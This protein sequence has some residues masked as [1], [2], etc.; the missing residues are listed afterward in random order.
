MDSPPKKEM[1]RDNEKST[2]TTTTT[3]PHEIWLYIHDH[4]DIPTKRKLEEALGWPVTGIHT[5]PPA[6]VDFITHRMQYYNIGRGSLDHDYV[7]LPIPP[8][9]KDLKKYYSIN[10]YRSYYPYVRV[11]K[12]A[13]E[14][15]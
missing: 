12:D 14:C 4:C 1:T 7:D 11:G 10:I 2:T 8:D 9:A 6:P 13:W 15:D 5:L 3:I